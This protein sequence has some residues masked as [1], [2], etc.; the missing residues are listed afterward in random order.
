MT[1]NYVWKPAT[2]TPGYAASSASTC[3]PAVK[4]CWGPQLPGD[5]TAVSEYEV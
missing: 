2:G 3:D 1:L 4:E 5:G